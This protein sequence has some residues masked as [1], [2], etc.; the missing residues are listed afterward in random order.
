MVKLEVENLK[1]LRES[2]CV[3][4]SGISQAYAIGESHSLQS[5][6]AKSH[7]RTIQKVLDQI[8]ILRP[9]GPDGKHGS[10]HTEFC[11]CEDNPYLELLN[12]WRVIPAFPIYELSGRGN[13]RPAS[14]L[15]SY[16]KDRTKNISI[17][18]Y[19]SEIY[20]TLWLVEEGY[21][22][23]YEA[24]INYLLESTFPELKKEV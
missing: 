10:R 24:P 21:E 20:Y 4:Q 17:G 1:R 18:G 3:A 9:L 5:E 11:G 12:S 13:I 15:N 14:D 22:R 19:G 16:W 7:I 8:D 2:L 6:Y 23:I